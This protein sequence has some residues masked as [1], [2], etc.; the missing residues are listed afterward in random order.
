MKRSTN[1]DPTTARIDEAEVLKT[2]YDNESGAKHIRPFDG[3]PEALE[4]LAA[5]G[6]KLAVLSNKVQHLTVQAA[7]KCF[8]DTKFV[9]VHGARDGVPLKPSGVP[10]LAI[11]NE[12]ISAGI[13]PDECAFVGDTSVDIK[14]ALNA[15]MVPIGV[16]WG[17]RT[18]SELKD[19]GALAVVSTFKELVSVIT[20]HA[21]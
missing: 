6:Y 3:A 13:Q 15:G 18:V 16:S 8:P 17:F 1:T 14:T 10:A 5:G 19:A 2:A 20:K 7:E 21:E 12:H 9:V 4:T 11:L